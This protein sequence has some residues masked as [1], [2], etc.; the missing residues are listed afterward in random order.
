M[1]KFFYN[2]AKNANTSH[3]L[4][5]LNYSYHLCVFFNKEINHYFRSLIANTLA[6]K[7]KNLITICKQNLLH[8]QKV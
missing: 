3:L 8:I 2:N 6:A 1:I 7:L 5:E 4:F